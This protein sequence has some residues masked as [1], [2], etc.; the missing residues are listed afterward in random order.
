M[1]GARL[2]LSPDLLVRLAM[3]RHS[4]GELRAAEEQHLSSSPPSMDA[5]R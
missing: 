4:Q 1:S 5:A 3:G 2:H